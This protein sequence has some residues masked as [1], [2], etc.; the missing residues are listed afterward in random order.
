VKRKKANFVPK[1]RQ[2]PVHTTT[3]KFFFALQL[4]LLYS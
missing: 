2:A 1:Q 3:F 4:S